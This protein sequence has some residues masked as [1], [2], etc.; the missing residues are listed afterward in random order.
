ME[1]LTYI[2]LNLARFC[3]AGLVGAL[4]I[5]VLLWMAGQFD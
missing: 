3:A 2:L 4:Y 5:L 1:P